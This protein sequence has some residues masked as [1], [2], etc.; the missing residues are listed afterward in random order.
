MRVCHTVG[1]MTSWRVNAVL[2]PDGDRLDGGI[3]TRGR[4]TSTPPVGAERLPGRF[5]LPGL[6]DAHCHLSVGRGVDGGPAALN[7]QDARANLAA[8]GAAGVT[9]IRDTG[10]PGSV[11][12]ELLGSGDGVRLL[13]CGRFLAPQNQYFTWSGTSSGR[14]R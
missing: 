7:V 13:A 9:V 2:L 5:V 1:S 10:S 14:S 4:W 11:T 3:T 6:V 8:A 12:L